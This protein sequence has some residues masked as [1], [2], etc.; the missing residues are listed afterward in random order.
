MRPAVGHVLVGSLQHR[1]R[2]ESEELERRAIGRDEHALFDE[3][4]N[5]P[6]SCAYSTSGAMNERMGRADRLL[7]HEQVEHLERVRSLLGSTTL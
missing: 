2:G 3:R 1:E 5:T 6:R 4:S 7:I